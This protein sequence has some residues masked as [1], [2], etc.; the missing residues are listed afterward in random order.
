M[1]KLSVGGDVRGFLIDVQ[2]QISDSH[3]S[4]QEN[5]SVTSPVQTLYLAPIPDEDRGIDLIGIFLLFWEKKWQV[6]LVSFAFG[7]LGGL[8]A[9]LATPV[10]KASVL[11]ASTRTDDAAGLR[12]RLGGLANL[13]GIT[14][15]SSASDKTGAIAS[16][17]SRALI[18]DFIQANDLLP[19][20]FAHKW[21]ASAKRWK[22]DD[23]EDQPDIRK[24]VKFFI[25]NIRTVDEDL[26][27]GLIT[28]TVE[29]TDPEAAAGWVEDLV[30][31]IN[32][33]LRER[34]LAESE[35]R[36]KYLNTQL[37][38][39]ASV[40][41]RQALA[42]LIEEEI[43]T[44]MLAQA[45]SGYAFKVIDPV[46]VPLEPEWP[47]KPVIIILALFLGGLVGAGFVL[48]RAQIAT[49]K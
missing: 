8:Y 4:S 9:F 16:L 17:R 49:R 29:W 5:E 47:K 6:L 40:E 37:E 23:P 38:T 25:D 11:L 10:Y 39:A 1:Y 18:E 7:V 48:L 24:G 12:A 43:Q 46:R 22:G 19:V 45:N 35:A 13:A 14:L 20:L 42:R 32:D 2:L 33:R 27:T 26:T 3:M 21:D 41:L 15:G 36:L 28:L 31:R 44:I 34:D 30:R